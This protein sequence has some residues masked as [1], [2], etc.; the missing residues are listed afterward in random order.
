MLKIGEIAGF[1]GVTVKTLRYYSDIDLLKPK[2]IDA[3]TKY[4]FYTE[5]QLSRL[6]LILDLRDIGLSLEEI[7]L[8]LD[9]NTR[10]EKLLDLLDKKAKEIENNIEREKLRL[11][12]IKT[13]SSRIFD[14]HSR[15]LQEKKEAVTFQSGQVTTLDSCTSIERHTLEESVW[16]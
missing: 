16:L 10:P 6:V 8:F 15:L 14:E 1:C 2:Y 4:R 9:N 7:S 13:I 11:D 3:S 12:N 5:D